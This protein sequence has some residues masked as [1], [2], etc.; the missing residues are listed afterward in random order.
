MELYLR[1]TCSYFPHYGRK[2]IFHRTSLGHWEAEPGITL[3][4]RS[5]NGR[6]TFANEN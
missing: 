1:V 6:P 2:E 3:L 4:S 5:N